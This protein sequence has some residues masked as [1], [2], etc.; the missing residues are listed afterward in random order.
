MPQKYKTNKQVSYFFHYVFVNI[1]FSLKNETTV[2]EKEVCDN[3]LEYL[4]SN[5]VE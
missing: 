1:F 2:M 3:Q 4:T 5:P